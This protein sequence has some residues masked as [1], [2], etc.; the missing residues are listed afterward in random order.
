MTKTLHRLMSMV[1]QYTVQKPHYEVLKTQFDNSG[2]SFEKSLLNSQNVMHAVIPVQDLSMTRGVSRRLDNLLDYDM[3]SLNFN[4]LLTTKLKI[5]L[6][7]EV[8]VESLALSF[9]HSE[10]PNMVVIS[11]DSLGSHN[12]PKREYYGIFEDVM[13]QLSKPASA[14]RPLGKYLVLQHLAIKARYLTIKVQQG[15]LPSGKAE[16]FI[17][18]SI[19]PVIYGQIT[20]EV[21]EAK[22]MQALREVA[23]E[24]QGH[25]SVLV[26]DSEGMV[27]R[28]AGVLSMMR[29]SE[30]KSVDHLEEEREL[31]AL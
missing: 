16:N 29:K 30:Q 20:G 4:R 11:I 14:T 24:C 26:S 13:M 22:S 7:H 27:F 9:G 3:E 21:P 19:R 8:Q 15:F 31:Q 2:L 23:S 17:N 12:Q 18:L 28:E 6:L 25:K 1:S 5:D 10:V